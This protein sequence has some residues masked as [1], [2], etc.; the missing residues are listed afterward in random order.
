MKFSLK[1]SDILI[2]VIASGI[3]FFF[4]FS[5]YIKPKEVSQV[6]IKADGKEWTFQIEA[7]ETV[8]IKGPLG[9]TVVR[10]SD[11]RVWMESSP[12]E[13]Q[14]CVAA[15]SIFKQGQWAACLPNNVLVMIFG[16]SDDDV[17]A[18]VW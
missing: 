14:T 3:T 8:R 5:S 18:V 4:F 2:I 12:C 13:N 16:Y 17:D 7:E 9:D 11:K 6:L 1:F 10:I 15:G